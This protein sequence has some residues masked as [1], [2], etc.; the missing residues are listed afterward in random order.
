ML[1]EEIGQWFKRLFSR[2][3][4]PDV[5]KELLQDGFYTHAVN[6]RPTAVDGTAGSMTKIGGEQS[7]FRP[8]PAQ[9]PSADGYICIGA[10]EASGDEV[11]FWAHEDAVN[12]P[13]LIL[14]NGLECARSFLIPYR[15]DRP[16][17]FGDV[18]RAAG[19]IL[20]PADHAS[21]PLFW[22]IK[23][24]QQA[25]TDGTGAY[26]QNFDPAAVSVV[27]AGPDE[28]FEHVENVN[29]GV[30]LPPGQYVY[31]MRYRTAA[32]DATN[33]GPETPHI[34]I[35]RIQAPIYD[36]QV[37][38][39]YPGG[40][41]TGGTPVPDQQTPTPY[42]IKLRCQINNRLDFAFLEVVRRRFNDASGQS[43]AG[44]DEVIARIALEP[45]QFDNE[46][47][48]TD[49]VDQ[50][51]LETI[52]ILETQVEQVNFTAP[53]TVEHIDNRIVYAN[54]LKKDRRADLTFREVN[55]LRSV[56]ITQK[57]STR[58]G[59]QEYNDGY[60]DP[61]NN[62]YLKS[63]QHLE[64]YGLG[65]MLWDGNSAKSP[66]A[67]IE[68]N[69]EFPARRL[70]KQGDSLTWSSDAIFAANTECQGPDPVSPTFDAI[71]QGQVRKETSDSP[72]LTPLVNVIGQYSYLPWRPTGPAD[73]DASRYRMAPFK[74]W[75]VTSLLDFREN[76]GYVFNPQQH[77]LGALVYGPTNLQ[78]VAPWARVITM[79][80]TQRAGRVVAEGVSAYFLRTD[81]PGQKKYM[82]QVWAHFPDIDSGAVSQSIV[83]DIRVNPQNYV[84]RMT[85]MGFHSEIYGYHT[86][87]AIGPNAVAGVDIISYADV[88]Y[89][90]GEDV[91]SV[92]VGEQPGTQ[93][94]QPSFSA[95]AVPTNYVGYGLYR[96]LNSDAPV[97]PDD[98]N[99]QDYVPFLDPNN[100][101]QGAIEYP[102]DAFIPVDEGR[103]SL[104]AI[105][106]NDNF[107]M[108]S[109]LVDGQFF[110]EQ[111]TRR[112]HEPFYIVSI[113]RRDA[114]V[115]D[116]NIQ[117]YVN[118]G[119]HIAVER[120][121]GIAPDTTNPFNIE[122][123][124]ARRDDCVGFLP[125]DYR[126]CYVREQGQ[127]ERRY[128]CM[129]N[130]VQAQAQQ[131]QII[132]DIQANGFWI[133]PDGG[134]VHGLYQLEVN[135]SGPRDVDF[136]RF[137]LY[138]NTPA[139]PAGSR[140]VVKYDS[141]APIR[142]FGFD[143][144]VSPA[145][146]CPI[147]RIYNG[148]SPESTNAW[149][150]PPLLP[151][152]SGQK[153]YW[154][155]LPRNS[156]AA[157]PEIIEQDIIT[158]IHSIRQWVI[159]AHVVSR[160]QTL[161]NTGT[162]D[163]TNEKFA[164][165]RTHYVIRPSVISSYG[166]GNGNNGGLANNFSPQYDIDYPGE[167]AFF[168]FGGFRFNNGYNVDYLRQPL[169]TGL[170]APQD[171]SG[172]R[173]DYR[174]SHIAS[175]RFDPL[176]DTTPGLRTFLEDNI[177]P[178]SE[179][180]GEIKRIIA[181]DQG[182]MQQL[183]GWTE[184]GVYRVPYNKNILVGASGEDV[185]T[186]SIENFWPREEQWIIRGNRGM[187]GQFWRMATKVRV[188]DFETAV[189]VDR[190][191]VY[192]LLG[193]KADNISVRKFDSFIQPL[194]MDTPGDYRPGYNAV[195]NEQKGEW[196][197]TLLEGTA[198]DLSNKPR[199]I[200]YSLTNNELVGEY[201]Y[202]YDQ[203]LR[204]DSGVYGFRRLLGN[205]LDVGLAFLDSSDQEVPFE[206]W[207]ETPF[208]P[209]PFMQTELVAWRVSPDKPDE[210][211]IYDRNHVQMVR[212]N[213][214]LQEAFEPGTGDLWVMKI[215][216]WQNM[217][218]TV[219]ASYDP[220]RSEPPQ[221]T[222]FYKRIYQRSIAPFRLTF[223]SL[224]ARQLA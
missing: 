49:P 153:N 26:F 154:Y 216:S 14:I 159:M 25:L 73:P 122:L 82:N 57:V 101:E 111:N 36:P 166:D 168:G 79:M 4:R 12:N 55:G 38:R 130:N 176:Q 199:L 125:T 200:C 3:A 163:P 104:W 181:I 69:F 32:G 209:Y 124:H 40:Q 201:T 182:G 99:S 27:T 133:A 206:C 34:T 202:G 97:N 145:I 155:F 103:G 211:R 94:V 219:D 102:L 139:P 121:I 203:L 60:S 180:T 83:Q 119:N 65:M 33:S 44:I 152:S 108:R 185:A 68:Q 140:I 47:Y 43:G 72:S 156:V 222:M 204:K 48:F 120:I 174:N 59:G 175:L 42:G 191:G 2:G 90:H 208:V 89:D 39:Q 96:R 45:G 135:T 127:P 11:T 86:N 67:E 172:L 109:G 188:N 84:L 35:P 183:Y 1:R 179:E 75:N 192:M 46:F 132:S 50:N 167:G 138:P 157:G 193:G 63:A 220:D 10:S 164:F 66:V 148:A 6:M 7:H 87:T 213:R 215:D 171:G 100:P 162:G 81:V 114:V 91:Y 58:Y 221:D 137:G 18:S 106:T 173:T 23:E 126:Y 19:G 53:K 31:R 95:P 5:E 160:T 116:L 76:T 56:P 13:P 29:V 128:L 52:P 8:T 24:M 112:F 158:S 70:R 198:G 134:Q 21:D 147:D 131:A 54:F 169:V 80:R 85:P 105:R 113:M 22:D 151:Y 177:F 144:V 41:T 149:P 141:N 20:F 88:Q 224:Q 107:Y 74:R 142:M 218:N 217:M 178:I 117:Q 207:V 187:P 77:A 98:P 64:R 195:F 165:P 223:A 184:A 129:T 146:F 205:K 92:N 51:F 15:F 37:A 28:W 62:T 170:G 189:W 118:T 115:P 61:V 136:L 30:G 9:L 93:G 123:F 194:L 16:L 186:Q 150:G 190:M 212:A 196:W 110:D 214:D 210:M 71:V 17:Q 197:F 143:C 161:M 78:E